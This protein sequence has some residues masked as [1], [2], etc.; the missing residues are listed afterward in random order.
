MPFSIRKTFLGL[1]G[2]LLEVPFLVRGGY[3]V[4]YWHLTVPVAAAGDLAA[5]EEEP[6]LATEA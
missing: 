2:N 3:H 6:V 5:E 1:G 4:C